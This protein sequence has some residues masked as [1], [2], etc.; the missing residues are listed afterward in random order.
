MP[1]D[2]ME[3]LMSKYLFFIF[4]FVLKI[5]IFSLF[6][7]IFLYIFLFFVLYIHN[8]LCLLVHLRKSHFL[9]IFFRG[10]CYNKEETKIR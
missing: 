3:Y 2:K 6:F 4:L 10:G 9:L 8:F 7:I 1:L 5:N